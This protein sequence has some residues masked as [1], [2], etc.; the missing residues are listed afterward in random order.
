L[1][2]H[3]RVVFTKNPALDIPQRTSDARR[4]LTS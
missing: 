3:E 4:H 2:T 1:T